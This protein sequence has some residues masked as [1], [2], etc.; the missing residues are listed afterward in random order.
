M[1]NVIDNPN[2]FSLKLQQSWEQ[3]HNNDLYV[4]FGPKWD[5][6]DPDQSLVNIREYFEYLCNTS[7][8]PFS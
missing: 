2:V 3:D 5:T 6:A 7:K 4:K 1:I 8:D